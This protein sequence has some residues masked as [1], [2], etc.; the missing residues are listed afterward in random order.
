METTGR[1]F[2]RFLGAIAL[3]TS[4]ESDGFTMMTR[5][6]LV[7]ILSVSLGALSGC[8]S[9]AVDDDAEETEGAASQSEKTDTLEALSGNLYEGSKF[10]LNLATAGSGLLAQVCNDGCF[11]DRHQVKMKDATS[12]TIVF[13]SPSKQVDFLVTARGSSLEVKGVLKLKVWEHDPNGRT[14]P[15]EKIETFQINE[16]VKPR[17]LSAWQG[18]YWS[19]NPR[20]SGFQLQKVDKTGATLVRD[21]KSTRLT[22][23]VVGIELAFDGRATLSSPPK[24]SSRYIRASDGDVYQKTDK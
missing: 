3:G 1:H 2:S 16:T 19:G 8:A 10:N 15:V 7:G 9:E 24:G 17:A 12:G 11:D 20:R 13:D 5:L 18:N 14:A 21:G 6:L 4:G 23:N 22:W